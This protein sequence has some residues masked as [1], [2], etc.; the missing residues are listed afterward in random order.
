MAAQVRRAAYLGDASAPGQDAVP[1]TA[2]VDF[3]YDDVNNLVTQVA[4]RNNFATR[5]VLVIVNGVSGATVINTTLAPGASGSAPL[6]GPRRFDVN[7]D[8]Y[9]VNISG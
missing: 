7:G 4:W 2:Y 9:A 1:E 6:T 3:H 5:P 8:V